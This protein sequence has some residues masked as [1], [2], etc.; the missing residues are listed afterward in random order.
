MPVASAG[1][2]YGIAD[3]ELTVVGGTTWEDA[4]KRWMTEQMRYRVDTG[5]WTAGPSLPEPLAYAA[6]AHT[7]DGLYLAGGSDDH[8]A[9]DQ[10]V[11]LT[12]QGKI[13]PVATLPA[14]RVYGTGVTY[15]GC[16]Y[17]FGGGTDPAELSQLTDSVLQIE[18]RT[19][20]VRSLPPLPGDPR[21]LPAVSATSQGMFVFG[22]ARYDAVRRTVENLDAAAVYSFADKA[23]RPIAPVPAALRGATA[24]SLTDDLILIAG[25]Y[26]SPAGSKDGFTA[27]TY[28]YSVSADRYYPAEPLPLAAVG[29]GVIKWGDFL[30]VFGGED[31]MK[32]RT[33]AVFRRPWRDM[34]PRP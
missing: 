20:V 17:V 7:S 18:M 19:G 23:W 14:P 26:G 11:R 15:D 16:L 21:M 24:C 27:A 1:F 2:A 31:R 12:R 30:Y 25:G 32:H 22:G 29:M 28:V 5:R 33:A 34:I 10:V 3:D 8:R 4:T 13:E 6:F 9:T